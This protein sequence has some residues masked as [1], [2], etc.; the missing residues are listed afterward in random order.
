[1]SNLGFN[2]EKFHFVGHSLGAHLLGQVGRTTKASTIKLE[3]TRI[4]GLDPAGPAFF[5]ISP[6]LV[7]LGS[8][9]AKFVDIIHTDSF[10]FGATIATGHADFWP[11]AAAL[12]P[13]CPS[14]DFINVLNISSKY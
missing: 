14:L 10:A 13:G 12:Q 7:P 8:S 6:F 11:N 5:P 1:M 3:L 9:D 2:I 4:T